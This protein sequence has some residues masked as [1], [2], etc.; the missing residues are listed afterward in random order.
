MQKTLVAV[1]DDQSEA[2]QALDALSKSGFSSSHARLTPESVAGSTA[3]GKPEHEESLGEKLAQFFGFGGEHEST[4]SEAVRR[5]SCV[6]LVDAADDDEAGRA[7]DIIE[8]YHPVDIDE[9]EAQWRQSGWQPALGKSDE[10]TIPVVE[11]QL[12]VGKREVQRG[13]IRV[14][15][16]TT[17]RPVEETVSLR[18]EHASVKR[19]PADRAP[20]DSDGAFKEQSF[21]VRAT[22]EEAVVGKTSRVVEEVV[23]GKESSTREQTIQ[24][25][26]RMTG[27]EVEQM[28]QGSRSGK[29][30]SRYSG[31]E[32][33]MNSSASYSGMERRGT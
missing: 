13:G 7:S 25:S 12:Q 2:R 6:L 19:R 20:T 32:R 23:I 24:D 16:R 22:A 29:K 33:R 4:Y 14:I 11:E 1:F 31:Q 9:R 28:R 26:V 5:G 30:P 3:S 17:E 21:E 18:E 27:V 8:R 10:T 15:S